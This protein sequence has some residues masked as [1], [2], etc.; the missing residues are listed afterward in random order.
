MIRTSVTLLLLLP[1]SHISP[2]EWIVVQNS[3]L[4]EAAL[5]LGLLTAEQFD[6]WIRPNDMIHPSPDPVQPA[7]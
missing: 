6:E 5:A 4:R 7:Q 2:L 3:T 1:L